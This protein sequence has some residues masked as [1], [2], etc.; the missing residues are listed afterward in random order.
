MPA[1]IQ[2]NF[3]SAAELAKVPDARVLDIYNA[4][5]LNDLSLQTGIID[6][7]NELE[8]NMELHLRACQRSHERR[9]S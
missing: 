4:L 1:A 2:Y 3:F 7:S 6:I 8:T 5:R 9:R